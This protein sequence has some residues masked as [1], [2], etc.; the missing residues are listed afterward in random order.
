MLTEY[1]YL[2]RKCPYTQNYFISIDIILESI[3]LTLY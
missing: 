2:E 1:H 3:Q